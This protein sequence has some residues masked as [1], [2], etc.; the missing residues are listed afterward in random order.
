MSMGLAL[1]PLGRRSSAMK[2][3]GCSSSRLQIKDSGLT[4]GADD[5]TSPFLAV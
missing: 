3:R 2:R 1:R 5:E 4:W